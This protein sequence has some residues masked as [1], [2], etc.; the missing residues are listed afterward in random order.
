MKD[1]GEKLRKARERLGLTLDEAERATRIRVHHLER[2]ERGEFD[3]LPSPAQARGFLNNYARFLGLDT[4]Q[5][6]L[7]YAE[8]LQADRGRNR[9]AS[10]RTRAAIPASVQI[11]SRRPRWLSFD[12]F[13]AAGIT[14]AI[15]A[16]IIWGVGSVLRTMRERTEIASEPTELVPPTATVSPTAELAA[17]P[18]AP[19]QDLSTPIP[20]ELASPTSPIVL[21][22]GATIHLSIQ[23]EKRSWLQVVVDGEQQLNRRVLPGE[24]LEFQGTR[25]V[26]VTAGNAGGV[27]VIFN[28][29]DQGLLG[30]TGELV[31]RLW[32]RSG[33]ITPTPTETRPPTATPPLTD[34]PTPTTTQTP[35]PIE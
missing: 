17:Q 31:T 22:P 34:T 35:T 28:G 18:V 8:T 16:L 19:A 26:Q 15:V 3:S 5:I 13:L 12:L 21:A 6:M 23:V 29:Q 25:E 7:G 27:R 1:I 24:D 11:R 14:L 9:S 20:E 2:L 10:W 33:A 30:R 32:T 4:D